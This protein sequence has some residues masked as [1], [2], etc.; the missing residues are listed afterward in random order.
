MSPCYQKDE[1]DMPDIYND[2]GT[3]LYILEEGD[4]PAYP[5]WKAFMRVAYSTENVESSND[6]FVFRD[7]EGGIIAIQMPDP[8]NDAGHPKEAV[9][10]TLR[11]IID[12]DEMSLLIDHL[13]E[14]RKELENL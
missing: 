9:I 10:S 13:V 5:Y 2:N 11:T 12:E 8:V 4:I 7:T 3:I 6:I 1:N 14:A